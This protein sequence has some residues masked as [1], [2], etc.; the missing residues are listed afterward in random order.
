MELEIRTAGA[1]DL[2]DL[3]PLMRGYC[4]FYG[5]SPSD[6]ALAAMSGR[7][8]DDSTEGSQLIARDETGQALGYATILWS[9]D[10]TLAAPLAVMEDLF[11]VADARGGGVGRALIQACRAAAA[12]RG[13]AGLDWLTAP[14]NLTAQRLY[15]AIGARRSEWVS[16]RL[17]TPGGAP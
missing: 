1:D 9:W 13:A 2:A 10:T 3:L 8:R 6:D 7:F 14:D 11:V 12:G 5:A 4:E 17:T 15:D 16:Y